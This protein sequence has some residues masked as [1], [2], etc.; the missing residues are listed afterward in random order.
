[1]VEIAVWEICERV[2]E[3]QALLVDHIAGVKHSAVDVVAKAQAAYLLLRLV[4]FY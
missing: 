1:M 4:R 3:V 2:A